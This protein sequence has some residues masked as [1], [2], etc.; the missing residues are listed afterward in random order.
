MLCY[1]V[2]LP[3]VLHTYAIDAMYVLARMYLICFILHN[4]YIIL[5]VLCESLMRK[6]RKSKNYQKMEAADYP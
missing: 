1:S 4:L 3:F 6:Q 5:F 2:T